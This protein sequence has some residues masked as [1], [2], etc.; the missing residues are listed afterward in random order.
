MRIH[1]D[2]AAKLN[3]AAHQSAF[4]VLRSLGVENADT[5]QQLEELVLTLRSTPAFI[6]EKSWI[7]D[8]VA[9]RELISIKDRDLA[10]NGG[11]LL[12]L[13]ESVRGN[14]VFR[15]EKE[16]CSGSKRKTKFWQN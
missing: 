1:A 4:S 11:F 2:I 7:V 3:F 15:L 5:E 9:P 8:R 13:A 16:L 10:V 14:I 6:R 12:D